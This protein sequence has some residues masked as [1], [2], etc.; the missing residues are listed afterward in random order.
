MYPL[1]NIFGREIST[2]GLF[3]ILGCIVS[4]YFFYQ[5]TKSHFFIIEDVFLLAIP[6]FI[7]ALIGGHLVFGLTNFDLI[8]ILVKNIHRL[9]LKQFFGLLAAVFSGSV[10]YGGFLGALTAFGIFTRKHRESF[11]QK[12]MDTFAV[13]VPL[14]HVFGRIGCFLGGCCY[15]IES[16]FG[17]TANN[18]RFVPELNG[19]CRF[20]TQLLEALGNLTVFVIL[21]YIYKHKFIKGKFIFVYMIMYSVLRFCIEFLRG[22]VSRGIYFGISVSQWIS[23]VLFII[24]LVYIITQNIKR[25]AVT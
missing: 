13:T 19:V 8:I 5:H 20:P 12:L 1:I 10:F 14:F 11:R 6:T 23:I 25:D 3:G 22:D 2:Y 7:G 21:F 17:L 15:G 16:E 9:S 18:N 4:V 24:S